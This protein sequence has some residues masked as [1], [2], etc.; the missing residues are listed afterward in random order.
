MLIRLFY[1]N[2][3]DLTSR[4]MDRLQLLRTSL[5]IQIK[6]FPAPRLCSPLSLSPD[7]IGKFL[8]DGI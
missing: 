4:L 8:S 3:L 7:I 1:N 2:E 5:I 6:M